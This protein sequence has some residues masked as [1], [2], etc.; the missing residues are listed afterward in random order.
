LGSQLG[1]L[2]RL[3]LRLSGLDGD[4]SVDRIEIGRVD[5]QPVLTGRDGSELELPLSVSCCLPDRDPI[6]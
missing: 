2:K 4:I 6:F 3:R 5:R 1:E